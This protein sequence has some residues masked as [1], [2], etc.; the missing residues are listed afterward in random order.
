M[1]VWNWKTGTHEKK[2]HLLYPII[3]ISF[4]PGG[5]YLAIA[6]GQEL[7]TWKYEEA[8]TT[9][10]VAMTTKKCFRCVTF[11]RQVPTILPSSSSFQLRWRRP[12]PLDFQI[13]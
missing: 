9:P 13:R 8:E 12:L 4:H 5:H 2:T 10:V 6:S 7:Y 3:S 11:L 1:I